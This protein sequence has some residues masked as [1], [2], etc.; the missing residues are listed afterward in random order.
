MLDLGLGRAPDVINRALDEG[1]PVYAI[2]LRGRD[3][4]E[5]TSQFDMAVIAGA[6]DDA[7]WQVRGRRSA[8]G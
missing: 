6:N 7:V 3:T 2:R 1:R 8:P 5:L 4:D